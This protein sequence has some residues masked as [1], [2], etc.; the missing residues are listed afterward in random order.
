MAMYMLMAKYSAA[1]VKGI[2]KSGSDREAA[3]RAAVEAA[4]GKLHGFYGMLGQEY[5]LAMIVE[6]P[7][8]AEYIGALL[9]AISSGTFE[10][11]KSIPLYTWS[12][13]TQAMTIAKKVHKVYKP[14]G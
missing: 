1:A 11:W 2:V 10:S 9:P 8:H 5:G 4:G 6:A 12:D 13:M 7:G 3:A 14:P